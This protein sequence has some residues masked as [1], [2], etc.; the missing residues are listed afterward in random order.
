MGSV[1]LDICGPRAGVLLAVDVVALAA[2]VG[3]MASRVGTQRGTALSTR[4]IGETEI[5]AV[6]LGAGA[7]ETISEAA[8][9]GL[10]GL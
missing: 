6:E 10:L 2:T 7:V 1:E 9:D 3:G 5:V 8:V 4:D